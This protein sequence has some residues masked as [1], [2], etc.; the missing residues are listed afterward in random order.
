MT[1]KDYIKIAQVLKEV[2]KK[3]IS[4][5]QKIIFKSIVYKLSNI[6]YQDND[7]FDNIRFEN[8]IY[9]K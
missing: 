3:N 6:F 1:K 7:K 9:G 2:E 8:A 5:Q 4:L